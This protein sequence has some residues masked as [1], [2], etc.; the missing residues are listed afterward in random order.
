MTKIHAL[1]NYKALKPPNF[2]IKE[3]KNTLSVKLEEKIRAEIIEIETRKTIE[4]INEAKSS[5]LRR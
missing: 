1:I 3:V 5:F 4:R 2:H